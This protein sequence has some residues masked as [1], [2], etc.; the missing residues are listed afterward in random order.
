MLGVNFLHL[1][2]DTQSVNAASIVQRIWCW[3]QAAFIHAA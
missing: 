2:V 3:L 1:S